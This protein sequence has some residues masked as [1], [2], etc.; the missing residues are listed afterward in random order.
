MVAIV[1][2]VA[3]VAV[4]MAITAAARVAVATAEIAVIAVV[5]PLAIE[6]IRRNGGGR[7]S[8]FESIIVVVIYALLTS[9][10]LSR[11]HSV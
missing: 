10:I 2:P 7:T 6:S 8:H 4:V 5:V 3:V 11:V 1:V 9:N